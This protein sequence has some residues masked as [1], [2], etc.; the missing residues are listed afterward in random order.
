MI[1]LLGGTSE[2]R[3]L[4]VLLEAAGYD[5]LLSVAT[6]YG[7][8]IA[9]A[10]GIGQKLTGRL[11]EA[12]LSHLLDEKRITA[13]VD[14]THPFAQNVTRIAKQVCKDKRIPFIRYSR[15]Q[16]AVH[17]H[18]LIHYAE[19]YEQA[20]AMA[21]SLGK[22]IFATVGA[23]RLESIVGTVRSAGVRLIVRVLPEVNSLTKCLSLGIAGKDIIAMQGPFTE[24]L[25]KELFIAYD[26]DVVMM[27]ESGAAGGTDTKL[28][29]AID[30]GI[31]VVIIRRPQ[32]ESDSVLDYA[33][34][35]NWIK[36][37]V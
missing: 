14:A 22:N 23:N 12:G 6:D 19:N 4:T 34:I 17:E 21:V 15:P 16:L 13:V 11:D 27:K 7:A 29:A 8:D 9:E 36:E 20:A 3:E 26:V 18:P 35:I 28:A 24:A 5:I 1:L 30:C 25:N 33:G 37:I 32:Q 2:G 31:P 10:A